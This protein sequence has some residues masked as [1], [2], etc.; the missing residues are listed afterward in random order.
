VTKV[1]VWGGL[2]VGGAVVGG[3]IVRELAF[4]KAE[5]A[6]GSVIDSILGKGSTYGGVAKTFVNMFIRSD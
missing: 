5:D 3:L 2:V 6:A 4:R 1:L